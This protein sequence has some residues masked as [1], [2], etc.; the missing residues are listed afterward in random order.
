MF[1][2]KAFT[3]ERTL[4]SFVSGIF[5][6]LLLWVFSLCCFPLSAAIVI[7]E[8][9]YDPV[10]NDEG[11]EWIELYNNGSDNVQLEGSQ[12][13]SAGQIW[14]VQYTLPAF[15]LRPQRF[16]LIGG[17]NVPNAQIIYNFSFQNGGSE[18]DGIRY[19][20]P[21]GSYTDTV[22]YDYPNTF[23][24]S[25]DSSDC[26]AYFAPD[27][28]AGASLARIWDGIDTDNCADDFIPESNPSP[29]FSNP[30]R[31]D[32]ALL[33]PSHNYQ[34]GTV[35]L[36]L[37]VKNLSNYCPVNEAVLS[38][39]QEEVLVY[40]T[41]VQPLA[42]SDSLALNAAFAC[43]DAPLSVLLELPNDPD[44][45][46]NSLVINLTGGASSTLIINEFLADPDSGNQEWIELRNLSAK[47]EIILSAP[48]AYSIRDAAGGR[49]RF[50][51]TANLSYFV[52]C[53]S[54]ASLLARYP[55]CPPECIVP[56]TSWTNLNN[57]GDSL[58]LLEV[59]TVLDSLM[60]SGAEVVKGIS[61]ERYYDEDYL[62]LWQNSL[63]SLGGTPGL[64][65]SVA[66]Q[67]E[68][69][70]MGT[71]RITG[72]PCKAKVGEK[73]SITYYLPAASNRISCKVFDLRGTKVRTLADYSLCPDRGVLV[74][75]G[76]KQDG[77]FAPRGLYF[78]LWES[79][80]NDGGSIMHKQ[81]T[82]VIRD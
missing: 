19:Q 36:M 56:A 22:L 50:S 67:L 25:D 41:T 71:I 53:Q 31:C 8:V 60:Y 34:E 77:S 57:D 52:I 18:T 69:P 76:K 78:I 28:N 80:P 29:G 74:W 43:S 39:F 12:I 45:T 27:V 11:Y 81:P 48:I 54:P 42:A 2:L 82:V 55:N 6:T 24:L 3:P 75:D 61:R 26:G 47:Q 68:L 7:N 32:Y 21:D 73:I 46:N 65:N 70:E 79:Q 72:S 63:S 38:I 13:L 62:P 16:L 23:G 4:K 64:P 33:H 5:C 30:L 59:D 17:T 49:I 14:T 58:V 15:V 40:N 44:T 37:F 35:E 9:C 66:P 10:G 20:N 1:G 51:L